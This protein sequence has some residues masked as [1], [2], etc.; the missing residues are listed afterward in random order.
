MLSGLCF[1]EGPK[2]ASLSLKIEKDHFPGTG[3]FSCTR[4]PL[5]HESRQLDKWNLSLNH[6][7]L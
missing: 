5:P 7:V 4:F 1:P 6:R 3:D 2:I